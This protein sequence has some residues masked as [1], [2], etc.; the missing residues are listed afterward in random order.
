MLL[1]T[2]RMT[3]IACLRDPDKH[4]KDGYAVIAHRYRAPGDYL[5]R[6]ER[7]DDNG[8]PAIGRVHVPVTAQ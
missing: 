2:C 8:R 7:K 4:A 6:V 1:Q 3:R 5:V